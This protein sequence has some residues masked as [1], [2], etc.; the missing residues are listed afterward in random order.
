[1]A[2]VLC[3]YHAPRS[4]PITGMSSNETLLSSRRLEPCIVFEGRCAQ[5]L[6]CIVPRSGTIPEFLIGPGWKFR[7]TLGKGA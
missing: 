4:R 6:F 5:G 3:G 1:M 7:G 2:G